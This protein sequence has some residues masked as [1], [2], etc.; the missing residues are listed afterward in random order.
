MCDKFQ[1][2]LL[3]MHLF[4]K[5]ASGIERPLPFHLL[6][7]MIPT[8]RLLRIRPI[9]LTEV[10]C[11]NLIQAGGTTE[12]GTSVEEINASIR[13]SCK[14]FSQLVFKGGRAHCG[15]CHPWAEQEKKAS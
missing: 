12:K 4:W 11:V 14:A 2:Q 13:S 6:I 8:I 5:A 3:N 9:F 15:W 7:F 10:L 1:K